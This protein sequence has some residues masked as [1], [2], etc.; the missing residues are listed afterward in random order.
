MPVPTS[1]ILPLVESIA[2]A[3]EGDVSLSAL[4]R[5]AR[6]SP[7]EVHRTFRRVL[8][9]T[10]KS[11]TQRLRLDLAA[12]RLVTTREPILEIA[13]AGGFA[14]HE[15]FTRAFVRR[16]RMSPRAY[17][18]RGMSGALAKVIARH[19]AIVRT[20][21]PCIGLY[22]FV[23]DQRKAVMSVTVSHRQLDP[24][25][26]LVIRRRVKPSEVAATLGEIL[27]RVFAHAQREGFAFTGQPFTRYVKSGLGLLTIEGGMPI[28]TAGTSSGDVEAIELPGG[29]AAV[30]IHRGPY[31][32]LSETHAAVER[33]ID[34]N[35]FEPAG[36]PWEV[37]V[38]DPGERPDPATWETE[39]IY[40]VASAP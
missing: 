21:G 25:H 26:A 34:A 35:H 36:A 12:A 32:R 1:I 28:A 37:Y 22:R 23:P 18:A 3:P 38:T 6:R 19:A 14:S 13:L 27:G 8:N 10:P 20:T 16:F 39:V 40:P 11:F 33:W 31:D 30:A 9:E 24:R 29:A 2:R 5:R 15:V 4:A 17:R 7:F